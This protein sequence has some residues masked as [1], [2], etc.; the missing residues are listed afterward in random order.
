MN[1]YQINQ[2]IVTLAE[3]AVF[4]DGKKPATFLQDGIEFEHWN[5]N[6]RD[7]WLTRQW[8]SQIKLDSIN[9]AEALKTF[10]AKLQKIIPRIALI[11]QCYIDFITQPILLLKNDVDFALFRFVGNRKPVGL[12]F[13]KDEQT[14]LVK[15]LENTTIPEEFYYY[16]NDTVNAVGYTAKLLLVFSAIEALAKK[17]G[18]KDWDLISNILGK[19][20]SRDIFG[21]KDNSNGGLRNRLVHGEY[22][23]KQD[24]SKNYLEEVHKKIIKYFNDSVLSGTLISENVVNPQRHFFDN[25]EGGWFFVKNNMGNKIEFKDVLDDFEK[26]DV[27]QLERYSILNNYGELV[28]TF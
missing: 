11:S 23:S 22:L 21:T 25:K 13:D 15:L 8:Q 20:L 17:N 5:F 2:R 4:D 19:E 12:M 6:Y 14:A 24:H 10:H 7:G 1:N 18:K 28:K 26:H 3:N 9:H 16:W 27:N